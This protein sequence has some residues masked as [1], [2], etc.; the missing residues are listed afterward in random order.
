MKCK[1]NI[2]FNLS[3]LP[4]FL[5]LSSIFSLQVEIQGVALVVL[6]Y[7]RDLDK[8]RKLAQLVKEKGGVLGAAVSCSDKGGFEE[9]DWTTCSSDREMLLDRSEPFAQYVVCGLE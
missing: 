9:D 7:F 1:G 2:F 8:S 4:T 5:P 3:M 6:S